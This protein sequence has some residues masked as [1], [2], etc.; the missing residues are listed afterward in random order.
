MRTHTL[1]KVGLLCC[2]VVMLGVRYEMSLVSNRHCDIYLFN[3]DGERWEGEIIF[4]KFKYRSE[5][6]KIKFCLKS[7]NEE[8]FE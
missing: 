7:S 4:F 6:M 3:I 1:V 8:E 5:T 2:S